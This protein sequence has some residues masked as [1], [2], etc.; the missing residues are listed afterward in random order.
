MTKLV[1]ITF[2]LEIKTLLLHSIKNI[3]KSI[4]YFH[5]YISQVIFY[6]IFLVSLFFYDL[7]GI[8]MARF[9]LLYFRFLLLFSVPKWIVCFVS[10]I[11]DACFIP[12]PNIC[13]VFVLYVTAMV[14]F[15]RCH[16]FSGVFLPAQSRQY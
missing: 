10:D 12:Y 9:L 16:P 6:H 14:F 7:K 2:L 4:D 11:S 15:Q 8:Q 5:S 13:S 3:R 1:V